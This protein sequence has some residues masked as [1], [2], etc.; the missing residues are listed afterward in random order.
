[1]KLLISL[2]VCGALSIVFFAVVRRMEQE[3]DRC[4]TELFS[5]MMSGR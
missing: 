2:F 3:N 4:R 5:M 1:M